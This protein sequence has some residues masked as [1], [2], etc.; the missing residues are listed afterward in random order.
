[1]SLHFSRIEI[2]NFRNFRHLVIDRFPSPAVIVGENGVGKSNLL[3]AL[4]LVLDPALPDSRR[5][6]RAEDIWDGFPG[7]LAAGVEVTVVVE[8]QG[9]DDDEDAK[10]VLGGCTVTRSPYTARL[11]YKFAPRGQWN[12]KQQ[13]DPPGDVEPLTTQDYDF[14]VFGGFDEAEDVRSIRRDVAIRILPALRD[15]ESDLQSWRRN[16][17]RELLEHLP[18]DPANLETTAEAVALAVDQLTADRSVDT[19]QTDLGNRLDDMLGPRLSVE[20]TLGFAS[21]QPDELVRAVRLFVDAERRRA[22]SESSLGSA[23]IIYLALLLEV[24]RRQRIDDQFIATLV[25][26]EEPEAH[27]HVALQ[28]KL[29]HYLLRSEPSLVLTTH[30]PHIAA[31]T[32][33]KSFVVLRT[34]IDGSVGATTADLRLPPQQAED[35][36]RYIDVSRAEILF[37][38]AVI[39]VE[40]LAELYVLPSLASAAGFDLDGYGIIVASAHGTDFRPFHELLGDRGLSTPHFIVTD[41]DAAPNKRGRVEA[42]LKRAATLIPAAHRESLKEEIAALPDQADA[43]YVGQRRSICE[44]LQQFGIFVGAQTLEADL[45]P[46]FPNEMEEAFNELTTSAPAREDVRNGI[47]NETASPIDAD[48]R[49]AMLSRFSARGKGRYAQRLASHL[50]KVNLVERLHATEPHDRGMPVPTTSYDNL[51]G[52]YLFKALD[53]ASQAIRNEPFLTFAPPEQDPDEQ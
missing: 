48:V 4:R 53:A 2:T 16:P 31:V 39:L 37:A 30:S 45:C 27:L 24:L 12:P 29:F 49:A 44:K 36:E 20:P 1:M 6:L 18:L 25:A 10:G 23:N 33:I 17:L 51:R 38:S 9:Y 21:S 26:V 15:A 35:I 13:G 5:L 7:G 19:L 3:D 28:R 22:V 8:L 11:T 34:T 32:P 42:G 52:G 46:V 43:D 41:G 40:G 14:V 50:E 47:V